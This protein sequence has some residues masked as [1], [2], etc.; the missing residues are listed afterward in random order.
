MAYYSIHI[1]RAALSDSYYRAAKTYLPHDIN[2]Y[3]VEG[4]SAG[5]AYT[6]KLIVGEDGIFNHAGGTEGKTKGT[7]LCGDGVLNTGEECDAG[8]DNG[9]T[10]SDCNLECVLTIMMLPTQASPNYLLAQCF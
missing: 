10:D 7:S 5:T 1:K 4:L 6:I 2:T 8:E 9:S 3:T